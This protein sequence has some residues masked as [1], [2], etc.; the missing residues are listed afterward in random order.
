MSKPIPVGQPFTQKSFNKITGQPCVKVI[1][2]IK[3]PIGSVRAGQVIDSVKA[4]FWGIDAQQKA[5]TF[6]TE[7]FNK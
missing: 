7:N 6:I 2:S 4:E 3:M 1:Q 5:E